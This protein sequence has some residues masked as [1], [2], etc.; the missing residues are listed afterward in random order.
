MASEQRVIVIE[1]DRELR[2]SLVS[3][4]SLQGYAV[5]GVGSAGDFYQLLF[6]SE[7]CD[8]AI[9]DIGLPDQS[10]FV[11]AEYVRKNTDARIIVLH[12][13]L[14][15]EERLAG[16]ESGADISLPKPVDAR[17]LTALIANMFDR[18]EAARPR[19]V[20]AA[21]VQEPAPEEEAGAWKL[22]RNEWSL[23]TPRGDSI[24][25]TAKEFDFLLSLVLQSTAIVT[26][27][28]ILK[29]LGY[30]P[31]EQG[32]RALES[33]IY[34]LRRK[35]EAFGYGFPIKTYRGVGYC[36]AVPILLA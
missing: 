27:Q 32:N 6:S 34:R 14:S 12:S 16:Y 29:I 21:S 3:A 17:E 7:Q 35:T 15:L 8:L 19:Q 5:T 23:L 2:D 25:L 1:G 20:K 11:L 33:L 22:L 4:L 9:I 36:L 24:A 10:G 26:R 13:G 18:I 30:Q 28:Y 31:N